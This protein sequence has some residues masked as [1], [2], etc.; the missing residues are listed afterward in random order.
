MISSPKVAVLLAAGRGKRLRPHTDHT[1][2]PLLPVDGRPTLDFVLE[3]VVRAG[4]E[5]VCLVTHHLEAQIHDYVGDGSRWGLEAACVHQPQMDGT[6]GALRIA[7]AAQPAWFDGPF[8]L[9]ATDYLFSAD[10]LHALVVEQ[11]RTQA[12]IAVSMK[13]LN[14]AE[15]I[16]RSSVRFQETDDN[17]LVVEEI[18]E[19]PAPGE[20]PSSFGASLIYILPAAIREELPKLQKSPRGEYEVQG[21]I[22]ALIASGISACG[23]VQIAPSEWQIPNFV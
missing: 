20:A 13:R 7:L 10:Y 16:G 6:A 3:A 11:Q 18:V 21:A 19:K 17:M 2:K 14:S 1:P 5:R 9:T 8:L 15:M 23:L 4:I 12:A 22:N